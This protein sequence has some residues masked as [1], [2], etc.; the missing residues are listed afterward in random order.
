MHTYAIMRTVH[1]CMHACC[2]YTVSRTIRCQ[3]SYKAIQ[4]QG[5]PSPHCPLAPGQE[6]CRCHFEMPKYEV[7]IKVL[8]RTGIMVMPTD[9]KP[10]EV[11][12]LK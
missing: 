4:C 8:H 7:L 5:L 2:A 1:A 6:G 12:L 3:T 9:E 10:A 11:G